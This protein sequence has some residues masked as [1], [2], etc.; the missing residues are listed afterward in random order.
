MTR[1][2][3]ARYL[4]YVLSPTT[5]H[6]RAHT[7][8][9]FSLSHMSRGQYS[10]PVPTKPPIASFRR[11]AC[12]VARESSQI[13]AS[14]RGAPSSS[15]GTMAFQVAA[16]TS[17]A[18]SAGSAPAWPTTVRAARV[19]ASQISVGDCSAHPGAGWASA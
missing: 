3:V 8:G 4:K 7:S 12:S 5:C 1:V 15:S 6:A 11:C 9:W 18:T 13:I 19:I 14:V 2:P 10:W 17:P 16:M